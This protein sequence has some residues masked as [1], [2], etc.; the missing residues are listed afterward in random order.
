MRVS[1]VTYHTGQFIHEAIPFSV[2]HSA[3]IFQIY[4]YALVGCLCAVPSIWV[5]TLT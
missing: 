4:D 3:E 5:V 2:L 1:I